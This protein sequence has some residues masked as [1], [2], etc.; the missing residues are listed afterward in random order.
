MQITNLKCKRPLFKG[1]AHIAGKT[2]VNPFKGLS[3][4][5]KTTLALII[6]NEI[7]GAVMV[8]VFIKEMFRG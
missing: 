1:L 2:R 7:R 4:A 6:A 5:G 3:F 8:A